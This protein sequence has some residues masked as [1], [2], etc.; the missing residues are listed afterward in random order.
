MAKTKNLD[1]KSAYKVAIKAHTTEDYKLA[2]EKYRAIIAHFDAPPAEIFGNYGAVLREKQRPEEAAA[3]YR[4]GLSLHPNSIILKRNY[5]NLLSEE[6]HYTKALGLYIEAE[7][8]LTENAKPGKR[9]AIQRQQAQALSDVGHYKLALKILEPI[10]NAQPNDTNLTLGM[11][12]LHLQIGDIEKARDLCAIDCNASELDLNQTYM[13][14]NLLLSLGEFNKALEIFDEATLVHR[15]NP[16]D[17]DSNTRQKYDNTCWNF[18]LM[19]LRQGLLERG[20]QLYEHGRRV[21]NGRGGMQRT[22]FKSISSKFIPE[23][24]GSPLQG[25]KLLINGEQGIGDVM[26][27]GMLISPLLEEAKAIGITTYDRLN[28]IFRRSFPKC[29]IYDIKDI[30]KGNINKDDWDYQ[31][32]IGS[33]P[34]LRHDSLQKYEDLKPYLKVDH[35]QQREFQNRYESIKR[36]GQILCGFSWKGGGNAKQKKTKSLSLE[37][38]LPLFRLPNIR[39]I[40]LQYGD[41]REE[42]DAFNQKHSLELL[43]PLDVDP[44]K[45]MDRW[46]SLVSCCDY[47]VSAAN[48]TIHGAGCLGIPTTV[49]L[50]TNPDWRWLGADDTPCYWYNSVNIVRQI[51]MGDWVKPVNDACERLA[52]WAARP[53]Q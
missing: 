35:D 44:L 47:V 17:L 9:E 15:K 46:S 40:S 33:L 37:E 36:D 39:W 28:S 29:K 27:F 41:V 48:T 6:G 22:V 42:I 5:G 14:S 13:F 12:D 7:N 2:L 8:L 24:D 49:I 26:M 23:W 16:Q 1:F 50:A 45:D 30:K 3:I 20:W 10:R 34:M 11:A 51:E 4:R 43:N 31:V 52:N 25:K 32:A 19:L 38:F 21:P 53:K 18:A